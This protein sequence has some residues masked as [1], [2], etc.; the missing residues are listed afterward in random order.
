MRHRV[1]QSGA[2]FLSSIC[3]QLVEG[4]MRASAKVSA[5]PVL[6]SEISKPAGV[7][8]VVDE[9][10]DGMPVVWTDA[11]VCPDSCWHLVGASEWCYISE[12]LRC[13][14]QW[15]VRCVLNNCNVK[16][17]MYSVISCFDYLV[18]LLL[19]SE[20]FVPNIFQ[21]NNFWLSGQ[22]HRQHRVTL[23]ASFSISAGK[24]V[25]ALLRVKHRLSKCTNYQVW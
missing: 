6:S 18:L 15:I 12:S 9:V 1:F 22:C 7:A 3:R 21:R 24:Q 20:V 13:S 17:F 16:Q 11:A 5:S 14:N 8:T 25:T 10:D 19:I 23:I 4:F 2:A